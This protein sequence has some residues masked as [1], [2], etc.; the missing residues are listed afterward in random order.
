MNQNTFN[1]NID[2]LVTGELDEQAR[3]SLIEWMEE[4]PSRWRTC[5]LAFLEAQLWRECMRANEPIEMIKTPEMQE[6]QLSM[7]STQV[8]PRWKGTSGLHPWLA[9][10]ASILTAFGLGWWTGSPFAVQTPDHG[11][12]FTITKPA[13]ESQSTGVTKPSR[14]EDALESTTNEPVRP[15]LASVEKNGLMDFDRSKISNYER[16]L[17]ARRG[18]ELSMERSYV[19][20]RGP[21][22]SLLA[23]PV[24]RMVAKR[25]G[26]KVN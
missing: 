26:F 9:I 24:D 20:A 19:S 5:G 14:N 2:L 23:V 4:E 13:D 8:H 10:A 6:V 1:I 7:N 17:L 15:A 25:V 3:N 22:G 12:K 21:D 16:Q 18:I 11:D